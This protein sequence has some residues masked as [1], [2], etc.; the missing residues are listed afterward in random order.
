[1]FMKILKNLIIFS[2]LFFGPAALVLAIDVDETTTAIIG[3]VAWTILIIWM[4]RGAFRFFKKIKKN[5]VQDKEETKSQSEINKEI[6]ELEKSIADRTKNFIEDANNSD[7]RNL[8]IDSLMLMSTNSFGDMIGTIKE[9]SDPLIKMVVAHM[10]IEQLSEN[11]II[12]KSSIGNFSYHLFKSELNDEDWEMNFGD[13]DQNDEHFQNP[14][15]WAEIIQDRI[16]DAYKK[17]ND[18]SMKSS[19]CADFCTDLF[20]KIDDDRSKE[21]FIN[22]SREKIKEAGLYSESAESSYTSI[23]F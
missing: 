4:I 1:M 6:K 15:F 9:N 14:V 17:T 5:L 3:L 12:E 23:E 21:M 2:V 13:A 7:Y 11:F 8:A 18:I 22:L 10:F 19:I 16:S 20:S